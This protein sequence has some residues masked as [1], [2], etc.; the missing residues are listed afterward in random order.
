MT[1]TATKK[2]PGGRARKGRDLRV[3]LTLSG[4]PVTIK[5]FMEHRDSLSKKVP[6]ASF[7]DT[8]DWLVRIADEQKISPA[9][10][11]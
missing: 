8:F 2:N 5:K 1:T 6:G 9:T 11:F 7:G 3:P 10:H 4:T